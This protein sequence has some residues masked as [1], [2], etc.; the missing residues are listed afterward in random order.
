[1]GHLVVTQPDVYI[2]KLASLLANVSM[3]FCEHLLALNSEGSWAALI[4][5]KLRTEFICVADIYV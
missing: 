3:G 2:Y 5:K 1:M 4:N